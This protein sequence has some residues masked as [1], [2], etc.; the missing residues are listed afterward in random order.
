MATKYSKRPI[1][2]C[3]APIIRT[4][5]KAWGCRPISARSRIPASFASS[6]PTAAS[7]P[8]VRTPTARTLNRPSPPSLKQG[9]RL[10]NEGQRNAKLGATL[11]GDCY[12]LSDLPGTILQAW[13]GWLG[14]ELPSLGLPRYGLS[15]GVGQRSSLSSGPRWD[16][17]VRRPFPGS[18]G[19]PGAVALSNLCS[20]E[21]FN[22]LNMLLRA[23]L[24]QN[25]VSP[26]MLL[27][28]V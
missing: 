19:S 15:P 18:P 20:Q 13:R 8:R 10:T 14:R 23:S 12:H 5:C 27:R 2:A 11:R 6:T 17:R 26:D 28:A 7:R 3:A 22:G 25:T 4:S 21:H 1:T 24:L 16:A 9:A